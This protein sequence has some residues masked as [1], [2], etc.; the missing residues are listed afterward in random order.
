MAPLSKPSD[1]HSEAQAFF[2]E[3]RRFPAAGAAIGLIAIANV[4]SA[5]AMLYPL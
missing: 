2:S 1:A 4:A 3:S 5:L